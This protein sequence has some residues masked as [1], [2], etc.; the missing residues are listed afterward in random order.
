MNCD[1]LKRNIY[2]YDELS[3]AEQKLVDNHV[4]QCSS[5]AYLFREIQQ[6]QAIVKKAAT[7]IEFPED[8]SKLTQKIMSS[9]E[10]STPKTA[11]SLNRVSRLFNIISIRIA[12]SSLSLC[13]IILFVSEYNAYW[14]HGLPPETKYNGP[15]KGEVVVLNSGSLVKS[16]KQKK[17]Q[18]SFN[19]VY[20]CLRLCLHEESTHLCDECKSRLKKMSKAYESN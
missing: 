15:V 14:Q 17:N 8:S 10:S 18:S 4:A 2:L 16:I 1:D 20:R 12:L 6:Q 13:L 19:T 9:V 7:W 5:C 3:D 11:I